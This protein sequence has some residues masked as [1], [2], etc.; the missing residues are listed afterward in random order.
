MEASFNKQH[1]AKERVFGH[2][3]MVI[4]KHVKKG[5]LSFAWIPG[6]ILEQLGNV[7]YNVFLTLPCGRQRIEKHHANQL[8]SPSADTQKPVSIERPIA[9]ELITDEPSACQPPAEMK[10][11]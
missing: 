7:N 5:G 2:N 10:T 8:R 6:V 1:G 4:A 9:M 3:E 11:S